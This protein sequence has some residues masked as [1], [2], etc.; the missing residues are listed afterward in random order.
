MSFRDKFKPAFDGL[1]F[2]LFH[3]KSIRLQACFALAALVFSAFCGLDA[4]EW[5]FV[6]SAVF[7]VLIAEVFNTAIEKTVDYISL[8]RDPRAKLIKDLSAAAVLL[9]SLYALIIA[10][11]ILLPAWLRT[12]L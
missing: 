5:C 10:F 7:A 3:D 8:Q 9:A 12:Y 4:I 11:L 6:I 2:G 1:F